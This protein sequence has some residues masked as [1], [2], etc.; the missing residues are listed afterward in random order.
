MLASLRFGPCIRGAFPSWQSF[1]GRWCGRDA[2]QGHGNAISSHVWACLGFGTTMSRPFHS[3]TR[4]PPI[5]AKSCEELGR[6]PLKHPISRDSSELRPDT[7]AG[8]G[9]PMATGG[10]TPRHR[11]QAS[12]DSSA[13]CGSSLLPE[14]HPASVLAFDARRMAGRARNYSTTARHVTRN[15]SVL[16]FLSWVCF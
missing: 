4:S 10:S 15:I 6:D 3:F 8:P 2:L 1:R 12:F 16:K 9:R 11:S 7:R 13:A 14:R 5:A